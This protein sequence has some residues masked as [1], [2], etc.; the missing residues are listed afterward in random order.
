MQKSLGGTRVFFLHLEVFEIS[1]STWSSIYQME[2]KFTFLKSWLNSE[3]LKDLCVVAGI[4]FFFWIKHRHMDEIFNNQ[5]LY[6]KKH[7]RGIICWKSG[8]QKVALSPCWK[9][10]V[11]F[12][13]T[14]SEEKMLTLC[15][16]EKRPPNPFYSL[17]QTLQ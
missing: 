2:Q 1:F 8:I 14:N 5:M 12:W 15:I 6:M 17:V 16:S 7:M 10:Q 11:L 4:F 3:V 13:K 9:Y